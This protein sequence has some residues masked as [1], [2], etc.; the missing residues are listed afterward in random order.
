MDNEHVNPAACLQAY[1]WSEETVVLEAEEGTQTEPDML[2]VSKR[3]MWS[4]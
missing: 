3:Y 1:L 2:H 4:I